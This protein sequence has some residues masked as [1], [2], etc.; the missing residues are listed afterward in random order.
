VQTAYGEAE[1]ALVQLDSDRRRVA[2]LTDGEARA[3][4]A[5]TAA[6]RRYADGMDDLTQALSAEQAW[7]ATRSALTTA[8][9]DAQQRVIQVFKALGGGWDP[10]TDQQARAPRAANSEKANS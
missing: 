6:N 7:R 1:N 10:M 2:L 3:R 9:A 4:R 5:Y 8:Q